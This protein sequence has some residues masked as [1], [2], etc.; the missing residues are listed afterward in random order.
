[1]IF[2]R[3]GI[4][5][6]ADFRGSSR[7]SENF[8]IT[9]S[10]CPRS[11]RSRS[12]TTRRKKRLGAI[13]RVGPGNNVEEIFDDLPLWKH[14]GASVALP[15]SISGDP[16]K[17]TRESMVSECSVVQSPIGRYLTGLL[18]A[19]RLRLYSRLQKNGAKCSPPPQRSFVYRLSGRKVAYRTGGWGM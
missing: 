15:V 14:C 8:R 18:P 10:A 17:R 7:I 12:G 9:C 3:F 11:G 6:D 1:M 13:R 19:N 4:H 2:G 5:L 16:F